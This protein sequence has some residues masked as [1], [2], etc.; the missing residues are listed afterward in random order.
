MVNK[1]LQRQIKKV[2]ESLSDIEDLLKQ[3]EPDQDIIKLDIDEAKTM[4]DEKFGTFGQIIREQEA[5]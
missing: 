3:D 2:E 4:L 1:R 5:L